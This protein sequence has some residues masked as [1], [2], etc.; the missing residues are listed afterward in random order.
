MSDCSTGNSLVWVKLDVTCAVIC[1]VVSVC[2][3]GGIDDGWRWLGRGDCHQEESAQGWTAENATGTVDN[4]AAYSITLT[5]ESFQCMFVMMC[6]LQKCN[7]NKYW[8]SDD[9]TVGV[10]WKHFTLWKYRWMTF[11]GMHAYQNWSVVSS[12]SV[13]S[14]II[15]KFLLDVTAHDLSNLKLCYRATVA[16]FLSSRKYICSSM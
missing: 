5:T 15:N 14:T 10:W 11:I 3:A 13:S 8:E 2:V 12:T 6:T 1:D 9:T 16:I 7:V 4:M